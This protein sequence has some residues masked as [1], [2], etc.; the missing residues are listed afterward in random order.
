MQPVSRQRIGEHA[1]NNRVLLE[2]VFSNW[3]VKSGYKEDTPLS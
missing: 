2:M 1:Y 3:P